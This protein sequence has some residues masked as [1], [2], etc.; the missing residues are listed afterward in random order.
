MSVAAGAAPQRSAAGSIGS[1]AEW[2]V[3]VLGR[4]ELRRHARARV[5]GATGAPLPAGFVPPSS[6]APASGTATSDVAE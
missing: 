1:D 4:D 3:E 6:K 5:P 2:L